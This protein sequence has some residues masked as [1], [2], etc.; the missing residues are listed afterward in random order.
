MSDFYALAHAAEN[1][2]D[3][4]DFALLRQAYV[5]SPHYQP[6]KHILQSKLKQITDAAQ[7]LDEVVNTCQN[8]L[9][10]SP[11][12]LEARMLLG[13]VY[14]EMGQMEQAE[15]TR[16]F[17]ENLLD[18]ILSSGDGKSLASAFRLV[19]EAE[20]WTVMRVFGIKATGQERIRAEDGRVYD[21]FQGKLDDREMS[22][23]FD[24]TDP[25]RVLDD[26]LS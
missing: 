12:D 1:D 20:A 23:H 11:L 25:V 4:A 13:A 26:T 8:I 15:Q 24:V 22:I 16:R 19:A 7:S 5:E 6:L 2:P 17:A 3:S 10:N 21:V 9:K 14:A 18:A